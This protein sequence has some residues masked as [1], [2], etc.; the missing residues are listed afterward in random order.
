[1]GD[2]VAIFLFLGVACLGGL[3]L[4]LRRVSR[5]NREV[6]PRLYWD[7]EHTYM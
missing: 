6:Y 3:V 5:H 7:W 4:N 1:M 2:A